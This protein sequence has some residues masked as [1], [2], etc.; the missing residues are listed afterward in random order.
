MEVLETI[1]ESSSTLVG[2]SITV[3][4]GTFLVIL[5]SSFNR[6][7]LVQYRLPSLL[8][9][10]AWFFF[11]LSLR[12]GDEITGKIIA[13]KIAEQKF[14]DRLP[15]IMSDINTIF[16]AQRDY[17]LYGLFILLFWLLFY[18]GWWIC[19]SEKS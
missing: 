4:G 10:P 7:S 14:P 13:Y 5:S 12:K 6:P 15:Q 1:A 19:S 18:L 16:N 8:F 17:F 9:V 3:L 2:W 11:A